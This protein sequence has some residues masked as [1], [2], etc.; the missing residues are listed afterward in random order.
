MTPADS[1]TP[2]PNQSPL[3]ALAHPLRSRL[4]AQLRVHGEAT[5]TELAA[6]IGTHTGATSYHL[7]KLAEAGLA[8]DTGT[9]T[10][11][12]RVWTATTPERTAA[13]EPLDADDAAAEQWLQRDYVEHF[14]ERAGAWIDDASRWPP[15]WQEHCGLTDHAVVVTTEQLTALDAELAE[16]MERYRRAGAGTPGARRVAAYTALLPVDPPPAR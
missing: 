14:A 1:A 11:R 5:A 4:L 9:G 2:S 12:R 16:V 6:A 15:T 10:G 3:R 7:R 8:A 13:P